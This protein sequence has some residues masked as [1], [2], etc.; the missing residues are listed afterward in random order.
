MTGGC[1]SPVMASKFKKACLIF[2]SSSVLHSLHT[3]N[4]FKK[5]AENVG[6]TS[7]FT[8][9]YFSFCYLHRLFKVFS[10]HRVVLN[11]FLFSVLLVL[12]YLF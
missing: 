9:K 5:I 7:V 6:F 12:F 11:I 1:V 4:F 2:R 10:Q 3:I 8:E